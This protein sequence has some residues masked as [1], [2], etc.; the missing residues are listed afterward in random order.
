MEIVVGTVEYD[1]EVTQNPI[2]GDYVLVKYRP[3][4]AVLKPRKAPSVTQVSVDFLTG[5]KVTNTN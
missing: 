1:V 4:K 3:K 5:Q 2:T